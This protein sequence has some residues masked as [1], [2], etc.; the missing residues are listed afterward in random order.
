MNKCKDKQLN[1]MRVV[2]KWNMGEQHNSTI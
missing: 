1:R 2:R